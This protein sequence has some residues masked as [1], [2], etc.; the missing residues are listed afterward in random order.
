MTVEYFSDYDMSLLK[1]RVDGSE[2][3]AS[4][5]DHREIWVNGVDLESADW[6]ADSSE[7]HRFESVI[8]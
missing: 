5:H 7:Y 2:G 6:N 3:G 1:I 8:A 4:A